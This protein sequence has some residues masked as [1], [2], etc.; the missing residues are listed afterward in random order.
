M[1]ILFFFFSFGDK[2]EPRVGMAWHAHKCFEQDRKGERKRAKER[3]C[4]S[5]FC[6]HTHEAES[7]FFNSRAELCHGL[8]AKLCMYVCMTR[9]RKGKLI[10]LYNYFSPFSF[11]S[12]SPRER[13]CV[14]VTF[15]ICV[16]RRR[17]RSLK[18]DRHCSC[19][20]IRYIPT[21]PNPTEFIGFLFF[22]L[23]L[24]LILLLL[25]LARAA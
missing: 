25:L 2:R 15:L 11:L 16:R 5:R 10:M 23:I 8:T 3:A 19:T 20:Y 18:R 1:L 24:I 12:L 22:V 7:L 17:R 21:L 9:V 13:V 4:D 14:C 6:T